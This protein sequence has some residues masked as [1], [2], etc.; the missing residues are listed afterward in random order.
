MFCPGRF[1]AYFL[2]LKNEGRHTVDGIMSNVQMKLS[3]RPWP[4]KVVRSPASLDASS[5]AVL[6]ARLLLDLSPASTDAKGYEEELVQ[7]HLRLLYS[8][9]DNRRTIVT[10]SP[11][12]PLVAEAS[13]RIMHYHLDQEPYM[14]YWNLLREFVDR[15]LAAQGS[16]GEL[17]GRALSIF[18]MDCAINK[19]EDSELSELK[20]QTPVRVTDY[21][22]A[23]LTEDAWDI[24]RQSVPANRARLSD[25][26]AT[27]TFEDAFKNAYFHFSHYGKA[28]DSSPM[29]DMY[30]WALWLRGTAVACQE[31]GDRMAPIYFSKLGNV[32][33]K[34]ISVHLDQD[35]TGQNVNLNTVAIQSAES[36]PTFFSD[37]NNL[38]CIVAVHCYALSTTTTKKQGI[39]VT[40]PSPSSYPP[41]RD[42]KIDGFEAPRYQINF[43]GLSAYGNISE[44]VKTSI[45]RMINQSKNAVFSYHPREYGV[46]LLRRMLPV[47][48]NDLESM[49]WFGANTGMV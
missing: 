32:S 6:S 27:R 5:I 38:P 19:L 49:E 7:N 48:T 35:K 17:I 39:F 45:R 23:L 14:D 4:P 8:V 37:G 13:A 11:P 36:L 33:P 29:C 28:N 18:A 15:G 1:H 24:L 46:P 34:T 42:S 9:Q 30:A 43:R 12:E 41:H 22:K 21:Y 16:I 25:D 31:L 44:G 10:G 40:M 26:S 2:S 47:L 3:G 20:Y